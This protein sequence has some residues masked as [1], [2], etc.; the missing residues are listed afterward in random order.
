MKSEVKK[1]RLTPLE[2]RNNVHVWK[3][4]IADTHFAVG[5]KRNK[6]NRNCK[7][8]PTHAIYTLENGIVFIDK[9]TLK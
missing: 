3:Q 4:T 2:S 7:N 9:K 1:K 8:Q 6:N 5:P